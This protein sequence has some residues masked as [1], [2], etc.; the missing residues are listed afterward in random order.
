MRKMIIY[1]FLK[2]MRRSLRESIIQRMLTW[3]SVSTLLNNQRFNN[4]IR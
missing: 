2:K 4:K 1:R 3:G